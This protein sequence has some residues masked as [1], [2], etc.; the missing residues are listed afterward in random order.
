MEADL[1]H[2]SGLETIM[3][4]VLRVSSERDSAEMDGI[5]VDI[6]KTEGYSRCSELKTKL[7]N[8]ARPAATIGSLTAPCNN[9]APDLLDTGDN[10][11][12]LTI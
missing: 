11:A 6:A 10:R 7:R 2:N 3:G 4:S 1:E 9:A 12:W 8:E 5:T